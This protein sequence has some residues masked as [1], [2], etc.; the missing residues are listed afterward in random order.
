MER[1][2]SPIQKDIRDYAE[3]G[4]DCFGKGRRLKIARHDLLENLNFLALNFAVEPGLGVRPILLDGSFGQ[5][6]N[7]GG[8]RS[9]HAD[10]EAQ[11]DDL[12]LDGV[13]RGQPVER[14]VDGQEVVFVRGQ[15]DV[16]VFKIHTLQATAMAAGEFAPGVVNEEMAHGFGGGGEEMGTII[17]GWVFAAD[18]AQPDLMNQGGGL[19]RVT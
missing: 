5:T 9:G 6:E 19:Q 7:F 12:G 3:K 8:F 15:S 4:A 13:V 11:L 17:E 14:I 10:E 2:D 1:A 18:E 16:H